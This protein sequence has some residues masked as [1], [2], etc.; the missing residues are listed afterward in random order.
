MDRENR[1]T[2]LDRAQAEVE[3]R[4][5][6]YVAAAADPA[7]SALL[8]ALLE[9]WSEARRRAASLELVVLSYEGV[10]VLRGARS[11][12]R[13]ARAALVAGGPKRRRRRHPG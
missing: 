3:E 8:P 11:T 9:A 6:A 5:A 13:P 2:E 12:G 10:D 1:R 7:R 4:R